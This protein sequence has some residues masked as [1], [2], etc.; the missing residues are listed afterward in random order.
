[1]LELQYYRPTPLESAIVDFY[2]KNHI[3]S[4]QDIDLEMFA[5]EQNIWIHY[6]DRHSDSFEFKQGY[7][8]VID[9]RLP[10]EQQRVELAHEL[11]HCLLHAG[12][13]ELMQYDF[14]VMQEWQADRF[15]AYALAPTFMIE[16]CWIEA[17]SREQMVSEL[18]Y[19]FNVTEPFM[20]VRLHMLEQRMQTLAAEAQLAAAIA[21]DR[22]T[23]DYSYRNLFNPNIEYLVKDGRIIDRR[24]RAV[25]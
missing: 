20:D 5:Y 9:N 17:S 23:Y 12:R 25:L 11:G 14:R 8:I 13:Q 24:R 10:W 7:S 4:P 18:A 19:H 6:A 15:A 2:R 1:M 3:K 22:A 21:E 16:N